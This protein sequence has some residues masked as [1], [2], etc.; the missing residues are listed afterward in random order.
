MKVYEL[1][2]N[3]AE[4]ESLRDSG[5]G[6]ESKAA[7]EKAKKS[8]LRDGGDPFYINQLKTYHLEALATPSGEEGAKKWPKP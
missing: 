6:F 2:Q 8:A 5:Y 7:A 3:Q 4:A 1:A